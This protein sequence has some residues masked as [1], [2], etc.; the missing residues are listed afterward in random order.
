MHQGYEI[1]MMQAHGNHHQPQHQQVSTIFGNNIA[2]GGA[3]VQP[4]DPPI[5]YYYQYH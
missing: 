3:E 2:L 4:D 5:R 1:Q